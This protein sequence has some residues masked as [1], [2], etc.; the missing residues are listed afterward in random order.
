MASVAVNAAPGRDTGEVV[1]LQTTMTE[2]TE[3]ELTTLI[4]TTTGGY[5]VAATSL[6]TFANGKTITSIIQS[7]T[8]QT[9]SHMRMWIEGAK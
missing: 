4:S 1:Y 3:T 2:G 8:L 9:V 5:S 6:G 7:R